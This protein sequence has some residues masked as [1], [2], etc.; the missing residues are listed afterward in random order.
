MS[1]FVK[2]I[3]V[4]DESYDTKTFEF[5][6]DEK[7]SPGQFIMVWVPGMEEI[8][9]SLSKTNRI[10]SITT[11]CIGK[12]TAR[13]HELGIGD[14]LRIRGPYGKGFD[15]KKGRKTLVVGGGVGTAAIIPVVKETG[16][17][18]IIGARTDKDIILDDIASKY[19]KNLWISTDDGSRGFHG[20][21]VQLMKEKAA[22][23]DYEVVMACGPEIM[24]Y[25]LHK[26]CIEL[27]IDCQLSLERHMKCGAGV[28]GC[29][30]MDD[31]RVCKD[32]PV[33]TRDQISKM[34][35]F[36]TAK[37]DVSGRIVKFR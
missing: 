27:D 37:R 15:I 12:D 9:M 14:S 6:W 22:E 30:V 10:K 33:F 3:N 28:C 7:A 4:A 18:T 1:D 21:A 23:N 25:Y 26:A 36:G 35:D 20:N 16:A 13:L 29:C 31:M 11:K 17:D 2:I 5:Q 32:G 24:L 19:V 34:S 8:P